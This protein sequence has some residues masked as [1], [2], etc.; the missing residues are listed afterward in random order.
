MLIGQIFFQISKV[1]VY[2]KKCLLK[3]SHSLRFSANSH[4]FLF[5]SLSFVSTYKNSG[6]KNKEKT[7]SSCA[8][9]YWWSV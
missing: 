3:N 8:K 1:K 7:F 4:V 6:E 2:N 9:T 5:T